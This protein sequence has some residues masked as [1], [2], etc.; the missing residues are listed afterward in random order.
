MMMAITR[1]S[2]Y[3]GWVGEACIL[4]LSLVLQIDFRICMLPSLLFFFFVC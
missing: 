3:V 2:A 1:S 4:S